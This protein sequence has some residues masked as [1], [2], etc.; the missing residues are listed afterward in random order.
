MA[1]LRKECQKFVVPNIAEERS[2]FV[3]VSPFWR[4]VTIDDF[5]YT[6]KAKGP[7]RLGEPIILQRV[8]ET[9][10]VAKAWIDAAGIVI[11]PDVQAS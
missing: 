6:A 2:I 4:L 8:I 11:E 5:G 7:E 3:P 10:P 1:S 9:L